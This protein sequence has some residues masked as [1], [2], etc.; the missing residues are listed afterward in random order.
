MNTEIPHCFAS[1]VLPSSATSCLLHPKRDE[2][3][4][5]KYFKADHLLPNLKRRTISGGAVTMSTQA[6]EFAFSAT[7]LLIRLPILYYI[8][9]RR[10]PVVTF[11]LWKGFLRHLP[12]W[13]LMFVATW[14]IRTTVADL[15]PLTQLLIC[16]P[17]GVLTGVAFISMFKAQRKVAIHLLETVREFKTR[18]G[19]GKN[20]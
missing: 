10:G 14:L 19:E 4:K 13:V 16:A 2:E 7:G 3:R 20:G 8:A 17:V 18:T 1:A 5:E 11:D 15:R 12:L 9:G 6:A